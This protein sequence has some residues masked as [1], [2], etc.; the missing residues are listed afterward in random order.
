MIILQ[1]SDLSVIVANGIGEVVR[2]VFFL[3][4]ESPLIHCAYAGSAWLFSE[5]RV[6]GPLVTY[7]RRPLLGAGMWKHTRTH[8]RT[9]ARSYI[10]VQINMRLRKAHDVSL[11]ICPDVG[12]PL[13]P[14]CQPKARHRAVSSLLSLSLVQLSHT[15]PLGACYCCHTNLHSW[16]QLNNMSLGARTWSRRIWTAKCATVAAQSVSAWGTLFAP[17]ISTFIPLCVVILVIVVTEYM[18]TCS[19]FLACFNADLHFF[20]PLCSCWTRYIFLNCVRM[21]VQALIRQHRVDCM[22]G[23]IRLR[24]ISH[25]GV[26]S[27]FFFACLFFVVVFLPLF[28]FFFR[29][30]LSRRLKMLLLHIIC[31]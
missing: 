16:S 22:W 24:L 12:A 3:F 2:Y 14:R 8:A 29:L 27:G 7:R 21:C 26:V 20:F 17:F 23:K 5:G 11:V 18:C 1:G 13:A 28:F 4:D 31:Y 10:L 6:C 15:A 25:V 30:Y 19:R 9:L